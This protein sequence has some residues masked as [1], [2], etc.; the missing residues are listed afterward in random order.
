[1]Y[2]ERRHTGTQMCMQT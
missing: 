2:S 1:M